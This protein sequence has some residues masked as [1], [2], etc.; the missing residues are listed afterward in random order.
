MKT[1]LVVCCDGTSN[2]EYLGEDRSPLTNVSRISRAIR[3]SQGDCRQVVLY[4]PGI[5]TDE[6]NP[7]NSWNQGL[8]IGLISQIKKAYTF[9]CHNYCD[10]TDDDIILIGFSRGAF[11]VRCIMDLVLKKGLLYKE[12]LHHFPDLFQE[13]MHSPRNNDDTSETDSDEADP[14][15]TDLDKTNSIVRKPNIRVCALWDSVNSVGFPRPWPLNRGK[16]TMGFVDSRLPNGVENAFQAISLFEHR[17]HFHPI[18]LRRPKKGKC[19]LEQCWFPGYHGDIG[20]GNKTEALAHF[21][22]AWMIVKLRT[23]LSI[24]ETALWSRGN[25]ELT[26]VLPKIQDPYYS[27]FGWKAA[28]SAHRQPRIEFWDADGIYSANVRR[29]APQ[30][31][32]KEDFSREKIHASVRFMSQNGY[33]KNHFDKSRSLRGISPIMEGGRWVWVLSLYTVIR[34]WEWVKSWFVKTKPTGVDYKLWEAGLEGEEQDVLVAWAENDQE[35]LLAPE[36]T[37]P[38][39]KDP[40]TMT[41]NFRA[42]VADP[43][44]NPRLQS[45][46]ASTGT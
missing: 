38:G 19:V 32:A 40:E 8:G 23:F 29:L 39:A 42:W 12:N 13:W 26:W 3:P 27:W 2:S 25:G 5:G 31:N 30:Y 36:N 17:F 16:P 7:L 41:V 20:G 28:G 18:V 9:L 4:L 11:A 34:G 37:L 44:N 6:N 21:A 45:A 33:L 46:G 35:L 24:D 43:F 10:E 15:E 22:L 14:D 1:K